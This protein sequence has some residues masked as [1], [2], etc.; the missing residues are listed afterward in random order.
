MHSADFVFYF[1]HG[2]ELYAIK[3][4]PVG[5]E[6]MK[7]LKKFLF[8]PDVYFPKVISIIKHLVFQESKQYLKLMFKDCYCEYI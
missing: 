5:N 2:R 6:T 8:M 4:L 3:H 7:T 1:N